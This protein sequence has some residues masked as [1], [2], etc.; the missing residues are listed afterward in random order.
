MK[1]NRQFV[2]RQEHNFGL[3]ANIKTGEIY[4]LNWTAY[5]ILSEIN[6]GNSL[7]FIKHKITNEY[8][9]EKE[10]LDLIIIDF[11]NYLKNKAIIR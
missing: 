1:I 11:I 6:N 9:I 5:I 2:L 7:D 8:T 10:K 4:K 3:L